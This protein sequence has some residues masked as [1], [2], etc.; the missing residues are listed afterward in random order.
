MARFFPPVDPESIENQ[1][2]R[3]V[4]RALAKLGDDWRV[5]HSVTLE[6]APRDERGRPKRYAV[7]GE[8]DFVLFHETRGL[9]ALEVKAGQNRYDADARTFERF[10]PA[11]GRWEALKDPFDQ[12]RRALYVL[13]DEIAAHPSVASQRRA[14]EELVPVQYAVVFPQTVAQGPR[15]LNVSDGVLWTSPDMDDPLAALRRTVASRYKLEGLSPLPQP[16]VRAVLEALHPRFLLVPVL[17]RALEEEGRQVERMTE[18]Q[19]RVLAFLKH[20][21]RAA[22]AGVAGSGKTLLALAQA[23]KLAREGKRTLFLTYNKA[24]A[25]ELDREVAPEDRGGLVV[26]S[27]HKLCAEVC[28]VTGQPFAPEENLRWWD[29]QAP[30]LLMGAAALLGEGQKYDALVC[31]EAQDFLPLWWLAARE[32]MRAPD[33]PW[34]VFYDPDQNVYRKP[35]ELPPELGEPFVLDCN[36]RNSKA[37]TRRLGH[38]HGPPRA[39]LAAAPEGTPVVREGGTGLAEVSERVRA[40]LHAWCAAPHGSVPLA[41]VAVLVPSGL[42]KRFPRRF[43]NVE[44]TDDP[45][46]WRKGQRVLLMSSRKFKGLECDGVILAGIPE[47]P[48]PG[49]LRA[50]HYVAASRGRLL[51]AEF[52]DRAFVAADGSA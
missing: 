33:Y 38:I 51:L 12:V 10:E 22:V 16:L 26:R 41:R 8:L 23:R 25:E 13:R 48:R 9:V 35:T 36:C 31:D 29:E 28:R 37:I 7:R 2:E 40:T 32:V 14:L 6:R 43:G 39:S 4:A 44:T 20:Q 34:F 18:A 19:L 24:I 42:A 3:L 46:E 30:E 50:D 49:F 47:E 27:F 17:W 1:G 11:T 15:P 52:A 45:V 21:R 5:Y